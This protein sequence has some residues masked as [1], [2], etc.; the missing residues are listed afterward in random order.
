[1]EIT[2]NTPQPGEK[3]SKDEQTLI[4]QLQALMSEASDKKKEQLTRYDETTDED[5]LKVYRGEI[6]PKDRFFDA[7]FV[8]AFIDRESAQLTDNRPVLRVENRKAGLRAF[9][10]TIQK[11]MPFY[12]E[13]SNVQRQTYKMCHNAAI[14]ASA[15]IYTGYDPVTKDN[16]LEL[17]LKDQ[18]MVDPCVKEAAMFDQGEYVIIERVKPLSELKKRFGARGAL[19]KANVRM[20]GAPAK[21]SSIFGPLTDILKGKSTATKQDAI[22]RAYVYEALMKDRS[23][24]LSG[25]DLFPTWRQI[26]F[27]DDVVLF[28]GPLPYWDGAVPLDWYDWVVDPDHPWGISVPQRLAKLQSSFNQIMDGTVENHLL[29]NVMSI[30]GDYDA[31]SREDWQNLQKMRGSL[32][33]RK[34]NRAAS[35]DLKPPPPFGA[36]KVQLARALFTYAQL[37][38]GVTD[39]T[40]G[41]NPGSLQ[42]GQ[43]IEG[44]IES[45]NLMTR[46]RASRLEDFYNRIGQKLVSRTLQFIPSDRIA[47]AL[48]P[49]PQ[50]IPSDRIAAALGPGPRAID[51]AMNRADL[52]LDD[53]GQPIQFEKRQDA[54]KWLRFSVMPGSSQPGTRG[55]RLQSIAMLRQQGCASR[56][57][58][59]EAADFTDPD[60]MIAEAEEDFKRFPPPGWVQKGQ[61]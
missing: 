57:M 48:G 27:T 17:I 36:D 11:V 23:T 59:L 55:K 43:A 47:A 22:P 12:W 37:L 26:L 51:Y 16:Y 6:G 60:S 40:L 46:S 32:I 29:T 10:S 61:N 41:E 3:M 15:G 9:A 53:A 58:M 44:L 39:V 5:D 38:E 35:I 30:V 50:F 28:D 54:F 24:D 4:D 25:R 34:R 19:V 20:R 56:K 1:M 13:E 49:G 52:F 8:Q 33:L 2:A 18:V 42:S 14:R 45:A 31:L 21:R 7:N